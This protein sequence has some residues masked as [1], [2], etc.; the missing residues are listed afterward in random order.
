MQRI[1]VSLLLPAPSTHWAFDEVFL[2]V[3]IG[4]FGLQS[5]IGYKKKSKT[6]SEKNSNLFA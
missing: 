4:W 5:G 1:G 2:L 3:V 6:F